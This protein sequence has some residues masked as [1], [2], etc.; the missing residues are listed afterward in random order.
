MSEYTE[1]LPEKKTK[2]TNNNNNIIYTSFL[3]TNDY[4]LEQIINAT[5][6][7]WATSFPESKF[8]L[9]DKSSGTIEEIANFTYQNKVYEPIVDDLVINNIILLPEFPIEYGDEH[10]L[11]NEIKE[12]L[13][14]YFEVPKFFENFLP[15]L[16]L[17]YWVYDRF[18]F[19]PY[20]HFLGRTGTGKSTAME[21]LGSICYKPIDASGAITLASIF[22]V[23]SMWKGTLLLDEFNPGGES[24]KEML[25][26]LKSGVS[27]KAVLRIEGEKKREIKAYLVKSPKI[28]T[29]ENSVTD[30]GLRSRLLEIKMEQ[31][32]TRVPLYR[33]KRFL[34]DSIQLRKKLLMWRLRKLP[35][36]DLTDIE[37]GFKELELFQGRVQ[38]VITPVYYMADEKARIQIAEFAKEQQIE[39]LRER[40]ES[41]DGQVFEIILEG[42]RRNLEPTL[43]AI[44]ET[45]NK[46][47]KFPITERKLGNIVRKMLGFDIQRKGHENISTVVLDKQE[48]KIKELCDYYGLVPGKDVA[49]VADVALGINSDT[50]DDETIKKIFN[51]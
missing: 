3:E 32:K 34:D 26:L 50:L 13:F 43:S 17:F 15:Y 37:Y 40:K 44:A 20:V 21:V 19:V 24:Y 2:K 11:V 28:F 22:R 48:E 5:P 9:L 16:V 1:S 18:P 12:F 42:F 46:G 4:I 27:N 6:A 47:A 7:T 23:A 14:Q 39:T 25:S 10:K 51:P 38:Q 41:I 35:T 33:Q 45:V 49:Y 36:I 31:N 8:C 30:A 29:S